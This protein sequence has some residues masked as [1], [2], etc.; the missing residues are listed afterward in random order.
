MQPEYLLEGYYWGFK[1]GFKAIVILE[2]CGVSIRMGFLPKQMYSPHW[3]HVLPLLPTQGGAHSLGRGDSERE[4]PGQAVPSP[5]PS[6]G[7]NRAVP[8]PCKYL[9]HFWLLLLLSPF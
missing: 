4:G 2:T 3:G 9:T 6:L 8:D 1:N 5:P 7:E